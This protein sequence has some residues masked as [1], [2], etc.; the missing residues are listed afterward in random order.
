MSNQRELCLRRGIRWTA[1][2]FQQQINDNLPH[3]EAALMQVVGQQSELKC[4]R[5]LLLCGPFS[6]CVSARGIDGLLVCANCHWAQEDTDCYYATFM[7]SEIRP[8]DGGAIGRSSS[9][10]HPLLQHEEILRHMTEGTRLTKKLTSELRVVWEG[11]QSFEAQLE[12]LQRRLTDA[13][14]AITRELM[15][16]TLNDIVASQQDIH[17]GIARLII[18]V[19]GIIRPSRQ[20]PS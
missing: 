18:H 16:Q 19:H 13:N 12:G 17:Q 6:Q 2:Q 7:P 10:L 5:C 4:T 11:S 8:G 15:E 3:V 9:P 1:L 14:T 20:I